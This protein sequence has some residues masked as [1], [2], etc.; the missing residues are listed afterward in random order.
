MFGQPGRPSCDHR[1]VT[2]AD[3]VGSAPTTT[4][5]ADPIVYTKRP[6]ST[7]GKV[8]IG[9][10]IAVV[11]IPIL[12][13][14]SFASDLYDR[15]GGHSYDPLETTVRTARMSADERERGDLE[16][17]ITEL[18]P[19]LGAPTRRALLDE[20]SSVNAENLS[21][22]IG[23]SRSFFLYYPVATEA[24]TSGTLPEALS[25]ATSQ[26]TRPNECPSGTRPGPCNS[27]KSE[28]AV[29][30]LTTAPDYDWFF[31]SRGTAV[32]MDGF[33]ELAFA[34][35]KGHCLIVKLSVQYFEG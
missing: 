18:R 13:I 24:S 15:F 5:R 33:K 2:E 11:L 27:G 16:V 31:Y 6:E 7:V 32:E 1:R 10:V 26:V 34:A 20:C 35:T 4:P 14:A 22:D 25:R 12:V 19:V 8:V 3:D 21:N 30:Q 9:V 28:L 17:I 29:D 23:C